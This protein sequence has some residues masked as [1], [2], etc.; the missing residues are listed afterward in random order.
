MKAVILAG[1]LGTRL[2]PYTFFVPKP[3]LPLGEKPILEH[4]IDWLKKYGI[5]EFLLSVHYLS[6]VIEDYFGDGSNFNVKITYIK[7]PRPMGTAGQLKVVEPFLD[8]TFLCVYGD[9]LFDFDIN[10]TI[11]LHK[12]SNALATMV[13]FKY[14]ARLKYGFIDVKD[15]RVVAWR[16][17]PRIKGL[18]N[19]GVY[20]FE[21]RFLEYIPKDEVYGMDSAFK[22]A[23]KN[24]E[25]IVSHIVK[26]EFID[27]GDKRAYNIAYKKYLSKLGKI[28]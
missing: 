12:S 7:S 21:P 2:L 17:K 16:E 26:G 19:A 14:S 28:P 24:N 18:I 25:K 22:K 13:L 4:L 27:I 5:R 3:M 6:R 15:G 20:V 9:S 1:G 10:S 8:E 23:F 11:N